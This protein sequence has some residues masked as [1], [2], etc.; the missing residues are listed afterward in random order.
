VFTLKQSFE[1][2]SCRTHLELRMT[3]LLILLFALWVPFDL[4]LMLYATVNHENEP[5]WLVAYFGITVGLGFA[6]YAWLARYFLRVAPHGP[7]AA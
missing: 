5:I 4:P 3:G 6:L 7:P 2:P 1:C